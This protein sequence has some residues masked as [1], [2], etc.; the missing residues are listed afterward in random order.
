ME[1]DKKP[2]PPAQDKKEIPTYYLRMA[3]V[4][5]IDKIL[6]FYKANKHHNVRDRDP[7]VLKERADN[8]SIVLIEDEDGEIVATSI[9][10]AHNIEENGVER[11]EW[12][13][14]GS[15]RIAGL[16]GIPGVFDLMV[17]AQT[18]RAYLVEPPEDCFVAHMEHEY[19]QKTAERL[20]FRSCEPPK[21]L[22]EVSD[23][24]VGTADMTDRSKDWYRMGVEGL[25]IMA[26]YM[27]DAW[28]KPTLKNKKTGE[29]IKISFERSTML[30]KF[31]DT[32]E[33]LAK[34][35]YGS[36]DKPDLTEGIRKHRDD[37]LRRRFR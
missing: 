32:I 18:L 20:G 6:D 10:Y 31:K 28:N 36:V 11:T 15:T 16:N 12:V 8:G 21:G 5:D 4:E 33:N 25:P 2:T 24:T 27:V 7:D 30:D 22:Q 9:S 14:I 35:D 23:K 3:V 26:Q 13:E 29:E 19:I 34:R 37:W 17:V 1:Q